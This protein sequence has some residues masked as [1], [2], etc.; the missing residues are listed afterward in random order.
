MITRESTRIHDRNRRVIPGGVVSVNRA[1]APEI[2]FIR[3]SGSRVWDADGNE[4]ID[5]HAGFSPY[6]LG[7]NDPDVTAAVRNTLDDESTLMGAGTNPLE[8][9]VA[10]LIVEHVASV[11]QVMI[12]NTG[13]EATYHALRIA[14]AHTGRP[15]VIV[16]QG[17]YNGWH[18]DVA[19]NVMTPLEAVGP[20][21]VEGEY[22]KVPITAGVPEG[23]LDDTHVVNYND[24]GSVAAVMG[25]HSIAM[26]ILEPILQNIGIVK[27]HDGY[28]EGL[29]ALCDEHG[30]V[31]VFD[32]VKT[33]FRHAAGGYQSICGVTPDLSVFGKALANGYPIGAI[34]G[35]KDLMS[36]F[37]HEDGA[38]RVLIAGTYNAHPIPCAAAVATV[39]KLAANGGAVYER[40]YATGNRMT[41]GLRSVFE[42]AGLTASVA[43]QGSAF[44]AYF[45]DHLPVDWHDVA[46][47]HDF[48]YDTLYRRALIDRGVYHFPLATKQGSVSLAHT[49]EDID[50]TLSRTADVVS[51]LAG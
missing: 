7:H 2:A 47:H 10:E 49:K 24:L 13:S 50:E 12:T 48:E 35:R 3:G 5:Y 18:N 27:P 1:V 14:R 9:R 38:K 11:D 46:E 26:I 28:L 22:P 25:S 45:A 40:L 33:G 16:M 29:R 43:Q 17:G 31:L 21:V 37:V 39:E 34:G 8:G 6:I 32:E 51:H 36:Y 4:Y 42:S 15:G 19:V 44:C 41:A 20:R 23:A 30:V